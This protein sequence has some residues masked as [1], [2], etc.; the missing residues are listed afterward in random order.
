MLWTTVDTPVDTKQV[1]EYLQD[2]E[3]LKCWDC[4]ERQDGLRYRLEGSQ[5]SYVYLRSN[6]EIIVVSPLD[7]RTLTDVESLDRDLGAVFSHLKAVD[8]TLKS[9]EWDVLYSNCT[10]YL[11]FPAAYHRLVFPAGAYDGILTIPSGAV[12]EARITAQ[13]LSGMTPGEFSFHDQKY[14]G[15]DA[16]AGVW[17]GKD[18]SFGRGRHQFS[19][20]SDGSRTGAVVILEA[21]I[22][23]S[24]T[25]FEFTG[26][27]EEQ[28]KA[29]PVLK[30]CGELPRM[31]LPQAAL[32]SAPAPKSR[33]LSFLEKYREEDPERPAWVIHFSQPMMNETT[34]RLKVE[35]FI[36]SRQ[37]EVR[38]YLDR[39]LRAAS[40]EF[41]GVDLIL[42]AESSKGPFL[43]RT[44][45][46]LA[47]KPVPADLPR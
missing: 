12:A 17:L 36:T 34:A 41:P 47:K 30:F 16:I 44:Y 23:G 35:E 45:S 24:T 8:V 42:I 43:A 18:E 27:G 22:G 39:V 10:Y 1:L 40:E 38:R 2:N 19:I 4:T 37:S 29:I 13:P 26:T 32:P 5:G 31:N 15:S 7:C 6:G 33:L 20:T 9:S 11:Q 28:V 21:I 14:S 3:Q 25:R 46:A